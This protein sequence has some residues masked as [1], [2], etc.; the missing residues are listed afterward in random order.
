MLCISQDI[1]DPETNKISFSSR[2]YHPD[3]EDSDKKYVK[4]SSCQ[5]LLIKKKQSGIGSVWHRGK[6]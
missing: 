1:R 3:Q 2:A 5:M 6:I 4:Y